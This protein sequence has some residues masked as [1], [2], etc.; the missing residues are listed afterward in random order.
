MKIKRHIRHIFTLTGLLSCITTAQ[1]A[2]A[3]ELLIK[4]QA[5][6]V[7]SDYAQTRYPMVMVHGLIG[8]SRL[9]GNPFGV[10]YWYQILPDLTSNGATVYATQVSPVNS[11][12]VRGEQLLKQVETV[13][14]VTGAE[15]A[16]LIGHSQGGP[17]IQ[18]IGAVIPDQVASLT[19]IAGAFRGAE[20]ADTTLENSILNPVSLVA[21]TVVGRAITLLSGNPHLPNN[22]QDA[23][24]SISAE[25]AA[26]FNRAYPSEAIAADCNSTGKHITDDGIHHYSWTGNRLFTNPLDVADT[27][28]IAYFSSL[29]KTQS[30]GLVSICSSNY[31]RVI[32]NDY[33]LNHFDEINQFLG[34]RGLFSPDPVALY[35]QHANR[36]KEQGL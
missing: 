34:L 5:N 1:T 25:G 32:R 31:G 27:L 29:M 4:A 33:K 35:R 8:F 17:T 7:K 21:Y 6:T 13:L 12:Q 3:S 11:T 30:D 26:A 23:F 2:S 14:A 18:Y 15:K 36:L 22:Y 10:D 20:F 9:G 19:A 28:L 24:N 16:N